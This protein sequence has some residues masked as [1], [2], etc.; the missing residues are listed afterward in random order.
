MATALFEQ[1]LDAQLQARSGQ[2]PQVPLRPGGAAAAEAATQ[3][4]G[5]NRVGNLAAGEAEWA[6]LTDNST[7]VQGAIALPQLQ[8]FTTVIDATRTAAAAAPTNVQTGRVSSDALAADG[9]SSYVLSE[10]G[11]SSPPVWDAALAGEGSA[12]YS[13]L[14]ETTTTTDTGEQ[15]RTHRTPLLPGWRQQVQHEA[16][17]A[18][19]RQRREAAQAADAAKRL[20]ASRHAGSWQAAQQ[21]LPFRPTNSNIAGAKHRL[22]KSLSNMLRGAGASAAGVGEFPAG[23][24]DT[25]CVAT[26][27]E[28]S[29]A[30][31]TRGTELEIACVA[32]ATGHAIK[33]RTVVPLLDKFMQTTAATAQQAQQRL[34]HSA[35]REPQQSPVRTAH[36]QA[37][38]CRP[39][40]CRAAPADGAKNANSQTPAAAVARGRCSLSSSSGG[41]ASTPKR[42]N[43]PPKA[44]Q[45]AAADAATDAE[46]L[47]YLKD[48]WQQQH[49]PAA[50][51]VLQCA[52]RSRGPRLMF[53][54]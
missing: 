35:V 9:S 38:E 49:L 39:V 14:K 48:H 11:T 50:A 3:L 6:L 42:Q 16:A 24:L 44:E 12:A 36:Q 10:G 32:P 53:N 28:A 40:N 2:S 27:A 26:A 47:G 29:I 37:G 25:A 51:L 30:N 22:Q 21:Q 13:L 23:A 33:Q 46:V 20:R 43:A 19:A 8:P 4:A 54:R 41:R 1:A 18:L 45:W 7:S 17:Q 5:F 31:P 34:Q 15:Q 52:W